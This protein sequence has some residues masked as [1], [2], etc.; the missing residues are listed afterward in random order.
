MNRKKAWAAVLCTGFLAILSVVAAFWPLQQVSALKNDKVD[1][2]IIWGTSNVNRMYHDM[3][4]EYYYDDPDVRTGIS[5]TEQ[6][7]WASNI[8]DG[9]DFYNY[10]KFANYTVDDQ[11][12]WSKSVKKSERA[13][14]Y[15][16]LVGDKTPQWEDV[17]P[18]T[19]VHTHYDVDNDRVSGPPLGMDIEAA[20]SYAFNTGTKNITEKTDDDFWYSKKTAIVLWAGEDWIVRA[21]DSHT[22]PFVAEPDPAKSRHELQ[23][24]W[25][26][27]DVED[28]QKCG[29]QIFCHDFDPFP[30][31]DSTGQD[32]E[33]D[34]VHEESGQK[35]T[36]THI[37]ADG[38]GHLGK[39]KENVFTCEFPAT[40]VSE[41]ISGDAENYHYHHCYVFDNSYT[42]QDFKLGQ[43]EDNGDGHMN[44][45][46]GFS[47]NS[48]DDH[49]DVTVEHKFEEPTDKYPRDA[50]LPVQAGTCYGRVVG[51][52]NYDVEY[53]IHDMSKTPAGGDHLTQEITVWVPTYH[54]AIP[55]TDP[56]DGVDT[57]VLAYYSW[58]QETWTVPERCDADQKPN[59]GFADSW[60]NHMYG[61][62]KGMNADGSASTVT[63]DP[64]AEHYSDHSE[65]AFQT[66]YTN[67]EKPIMKV[68][69]ETRNVK[70]Y[71]AYWQW[72]G[73]NNDPH[74]PVGDK[75]N[76]A[77]MVY[78]F[79]L[80][81]YNKS[82][83]ADQKDEDWTDSY[84]F[85]GQ[86]MAD[87]WEN[88]AVVEGFGIDTDG[89]G[90]K[91]HSPTDNAGSIA[92]DGEW[93]DIEYRIDNT[94]YP[95]TLPGTF[96]HIDE[97]A[98]TD[99]IEKARTD[100]NSAV[101]S[102]LNG[103]KFVDIYQL[104]LDH[105]PYFRYQ[106]L[107]TSGATTRSDAQHGKW[108]D[109]NTNNWIFH[110]IYSTILA[111]NPPDT[112]E[113]PVDVSFYAASCSLTAYAN[114]TV[115]GMGRPG[116]DPSGDYVHTLEEIEAG[117]WSA[118]G[119]ALGYGDTDYGF[120]PG[121]MV[122]T[123]SE[124]SSYVDYASLIGLENA[125]G[126]GPGTSSSMYLY[127]RYGRLLQDLGIDKTGTTQ[128]ISPRAVPGALFSLMYVGN[129]AVAAVWDFSLELLKMLN[130]FQLLHDASS[131]SMAAKLGMDAAG[132]SSG[133]L[134]QQAAT[135]P[136]LAK[137]LE[138]VG[139]VYDFLTGQTV[140][141]NEISDPFTGAPGVGTTTMTFSFM[142]MYLIL[143]I[144]GSLLFYFSWKNSGKM[145]NEVAKLAIRIVF[146]CIG[147][148]MLG[149]LYTGVINGVAD[150]M[151]VQVA[152]S[153]Q[154]VSASFVNFSEWVRAN[155][156][157]PPSGVTM[158]SEEG[159]TAGGAASEQ[160][161]NTLRNTAYTL[162]HTVTKVTESVD[163]T[164]FDTAFL[165]DLS[166]WNGDMVQQRQSGTGSFGD[167]LGSTNECL[168]LLKDWMKGEFYYSSDFQSDSMAAFTNYALATDP[169]MIGRRKGIDEDT[170]ATGYEDDIKNSLYQMF[171]ALD[172]AS[173][174]GR[175]VSDNVELFTDS[176]QFTAGSSEDTDWHNF[177]IFANDNAMASPTSSVKADTTVTFSHGGVS[178]TPVATVPQGLQLQVKTGLSTLAMYNYL[179]TE[180]TPSGLRIYSTALS[181]NSHTP[182]AHYKVNMIGSGAIQL[183]FGLNLFALLFAI[184]VISFCYSIGMVISVLKQSLH[185]IMSVPGA[186]MGFLPMIA[187]FI[188]I[189][190]SMIIEIIGSLVLYHTVGELIF[191]MMT[192]METV[193]DPAIHSVQAS[194][195]VGGM[196]AMIQS[197]SPDAL[198]G[199][200]PSFMLH[201]LMSSVLTIGISL[202]A[203]QFAP[204]FQRV[205][206]KAIDWYYRKMLAPEVIAE[207]DRR[208]QP[209][210]RPVREPVFTGVWACI[211]QLLTD[212]G[213]QDAQM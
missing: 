44:L 152:P 137:I 101:K 110:M 24:E 61:G 195:L 82:I 159:S 122:S 136:G 11:I 72:Y 38:N 64:S 131:I 189:L 190:V 62:I 16:S 17:D 143:F 129:A 92:Q 89:D 193:I 35:G 71:A 45:G 59:A 116:D 120:V 27:L 98:R 12:G 56:D 77:P 194:G 4:T 151:D 32:P 73:T 126:G 13:S 43:W 55:D 150:S 210:S 40:S 170:E 114:K 46:S 100:F 60:H 42:I 185:L 196:L 75:N 212:T 25:M 213:W 99:R 102:N 48:A 172:E 156:L 181:A 67:P 203:A 94:R 76:G 90:I 68:E 28:D 198:I 83:Y 135:N 96:N 166:S 140:V 191:S 171:S 184:V 30:G 9:Y 103:V 192:V 70:G 121:G 37:I 145:K 177:N 10:G 113:D 39:E 125:S 74:A 205:F 208:R 148:P 127:T 118:A 78:V 47:Y 209:V 207:A 211:K 15:T 163:I 18:A 58:T 128:A 2:M 86:P 142:T 7:I 52:Y 5:E 91:D 134:V 160:S 14:Q 41:R 50:D 180:F 36:G 130:P 206:A 19:Y 161:L 179:A 104:T 173:W 155:R 146:F 106:N 8:A 162:N 69:K 202:K 66:W 188:V 6:H 20:L 49:I 63:D 199:S 54:A 34:V 139:A 167:I 183:M 107:M 157:D 117:G 33:G 112:L 176:G 182:S 141:V 97:I 187:Q 133:W 22:G 200:T 154:M 105:T 153:S 165:N 119:A 149:T 109:Q 186:M 132:S 178:G 80:G 201:L 87:I 123:S 164:G 26:G 144:A 168:N 204:A 79:G 3:Q 111:D 169:T 51:G 57:S 23:V 21:W 158:V 115:S 29:G 81:P 93:S 65:T 124:T 53:L 31:I 85:A 147:V 175:K 197:V 84:Q 174:E 95:G 108:Y 138:D 88:S 1:G